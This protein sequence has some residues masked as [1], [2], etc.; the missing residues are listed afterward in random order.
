MNNDDPMS[1]KDKAAVELDKKRHP[2][3]RYLVNQDNLKFNIGDI[4][5]RQ[6]ARWKNADDIVWENEAV[7]TVSNA[8][9]KFIYAF[10]NEVGVGYVKQLRA[11]GKGYTDSLICLADVDT[12]HTRFVIDPDYQ[13]HILI[14]DGN[15]EH[16][17]FFHEDKKR[18]QEILKKNKA[19]LT[20]TG[21]WAQVNDALATLKVGDKIWY[22]SD[23]YRAVKSPYTI[24][25]ISSKPL[26]SMGTWEV[27]GNDNTTDT[28]YEIKVTNKDKIDRTMSTSYL[29][30]GK[31]FLQEP[32]PFEDQI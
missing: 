4:L 11:T 25:K 15:F 27:Y 22:G 29:A 20:P 1:K 3:V 7:S 8:P 5:I 14:G 21:T 28:M 26:K 19:L 12:S 24:L 30:K 31:L 10:E 17:K 6:R 9:K 13:D 18:R 2:V 16:S 23:V 32:L